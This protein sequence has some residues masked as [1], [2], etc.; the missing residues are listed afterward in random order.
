D[1]DE[2][3]YRA[4][5]RGVRVPEQH[6]R[7]RANDDEE[8][9][10][11]ALAE[12]ARPYPLALHRDRMRRAHPGAPP[13]GAA[14]GW[15]RTARVTSLR[16]ARRELAHFLRETELGLEDCLKLGI[17]PAARGRDH[18]RPEA[19][20]FGTGEDAAARA[21]RHGLAFVVQDLERAA[22]RGAL[23]GHL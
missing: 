10:E 4:S 8:R 17:P 15:R 20:S 14:G 1:A 7:G 5:Q 2:L 16:D 6:H 21:T 11:H 13:R 23:L 9:R 3:F 22:A 18:D 19:G 12:P